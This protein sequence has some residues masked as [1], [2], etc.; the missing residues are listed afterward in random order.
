MQIFNN[1]ENVFLII[2]AGI[3]LRVLIEFTSKYSQNNILEPLNCA[4]ISP[5]YPVQSSTPGSGPTPSPEQNAQFAEYTNQLNELSYQINYLLLQ[6]YT[7]SHSVN[8]NPNLIAIAAPTETEFG[9]SQQSEPILPNTSDYANIPGYGFLTQGSN[10][11]PTQG[12]TQS[13]TQGPTQ[14]PTPAPTTLPPQLSLPNSLIANQLNLIISIPQGA[15]GAQG[16]QGAKGAQGVQGAQ[17]DQG[18]QGKVG[19]VVSYL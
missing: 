4:T 6:A 12:P 7:V 3:F 17:G 14:S 19:A 13:P 18:K 15:K 10:Q 9:L 5:T 11:G 16:P 2:V 1:I 8:S